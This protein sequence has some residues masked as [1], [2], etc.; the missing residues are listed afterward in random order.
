MSSVASVCIRVHNAKQMNTCVILVLLASTS[1]WAEQ[2]DPDYKLLSAIAS[3]RTVKCVMAKR[4]NARQR[5]ERTVLYAK[6]ILLDPSSRTAAQGLLVNL[7]ST[8]NELTAFMTLPDWHEG[9]TTST[10]DMKKMAVI[11]ESWPRLISAAVQRFPQY[12]PEYIRYGRL[13]VN[14]IH[15]NYTG[16]AR[17]VC[18]ANR[19]RFLTA[20]N[21][22]NAGDQQFIK[23]HVFDPE[24]CEPIFVSEAD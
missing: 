21:S 14:D 13:A 3:C 11:Y 8:E 12:L 10:A 2:H 7:P 20:F 22:L 18:R 9:V 4:S 5:V 16:F 15:S 24:T 19:G 23:S 1:V 6:W 17:S